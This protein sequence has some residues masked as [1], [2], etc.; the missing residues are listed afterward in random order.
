MKIFSTSF[1]YLQKLVLKLRYLSSRRYI[2]FVY[3]I[4]TTLLSSGN[5][6]ALSDCDPTSW[7]L[8]ESFKTQFI[9]SSGR[10]IAGSYPQFQSFSEG[11]AYAMT[12]ALINNDPKTFDAIWQWTLKN[13]MKNDIASTLPAWTWGKNEN[14]KW[15]VLDENSATDA[16]LWLA[17][18]LLEAG[19]LW[20]RKDFIANA[21]SILALIEKK[22][23]VT[24]P[25]FGKILLP[26]PYGFYIQP[27]QWKLN[28]SYFPIPVLRRL[29]LNSNKSLWTEITNNTA[30]MIALTSPNG[31]VPDWIIY[32]SLSPIT[33][34]FVS[35]QG[36]GDVGSY[37]AIRV[38]MW[39]GM[40]SPQDPLA[41]SVMKSL[42]GMQKYLSSNDI[43]PENINTVNGE[44]SGIGLIGF[45]SALLPY[46]SSE[47][48]K[49][50]LRVQASRAQSVLSSNQI[51][52]YNYVLS[53]FG[54]GW[55]EGRYS[56]SSNGQINLNWSGICTKKTS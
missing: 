47:N 50:Q 28:P 17:Y 4:F 54:L 12:F 53:L 20:G 42:N 56:F 34:K 41:F 49:S 8:W 13:L 3:T 46:L 6:Y 52:Y 29:A 23:L 24:L 19:R 21:N 5:V 16:D 30:K 18:T 40:T 14:G 11:Q 35:D 26:G 7:P 1:V 27:N 22:S 33:G 2:L 15:Q 36:K 39:A 55:Y 44:T 31:Y 51:L 38:Y 48:Q 37:D 32:Q 43:P 45:S 10:V 25:G 9:E